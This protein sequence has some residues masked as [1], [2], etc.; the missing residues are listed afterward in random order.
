M[1]TDGGWH[2]KTAQYHCRTPSS[3]AVVSPLPVYTD[4]AANAFECEGSSGVE[5]LDSRPVST[6]TELPGSAPTGLSKSAAEGRKEGSVELSDSDQNI[7]RSRLSQVLPPAITIA[8]EDK[9]GDATRRTYLPGL[10]SPPGTPHAHTA[11]ANDHPISSSPE[12][13][14]MPRTLSANVATTD[15]SRK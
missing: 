12:A 1:A 14:A 10:G 4:D 13:N 2:D 5:Q 15:D 3:T 11:G 6:V 9:A 8:R 7:R